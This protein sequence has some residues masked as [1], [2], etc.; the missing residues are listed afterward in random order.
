VGD[1][2][3]IPVGLVIFVLTSVTAQSA[4]LIVSNT[5]DALAGSLRPTVATAGA[6]DTIEFNIPTSD[7]GYDTSTGVFTITLT[8]GE[9]VIDKNL[10]I[11]A[12]GKRIAISGNHAS[13][14]FNVTAGKVVSQLSLSSMVEPGAANRPPGPN[15]FRGSDREFKLANISTR[16]FVQSGDNVMI[17]GLLCGAGFAESDRAR[18]GG[19]APPVRDARQSKAADV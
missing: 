13:R 7:P 15:A 12:H 14:I 10:N 1:A 19:V 17:G 9:I 8:S 16:G 6:G 18:D 3:C 5:Q 4:V 2:D 11:A